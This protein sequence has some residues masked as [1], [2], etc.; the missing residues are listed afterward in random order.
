MGFYSHHWHP[1]TIHL[2]AMQENIILTLINLWNDQE[3]KINKILK[4]KVITWTFIFDTP[5]TSKTTS[6]NKPTRSM[7]VENGERKETDH[8]SPVVTTHQQQLCQNQNM[9]LPV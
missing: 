8:D 4:T 7:K 5:I 2:H 1:K 9:H 6:N 3:L